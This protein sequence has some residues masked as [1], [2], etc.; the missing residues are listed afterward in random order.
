MSLRFGSCPILD[1]LFSHP[2]TRPPS[3]YPPTRCG[4]SRPDKSISCKKNYL[5]R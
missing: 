3:S 1:L 2:P 4:L 5:D